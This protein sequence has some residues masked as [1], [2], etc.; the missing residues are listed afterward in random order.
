MAKKDAAKALPRLR[1][2]EFRSLS[3]WESTL[4]GD[5]SIPVTERVGDRKLTPISISAG[6]GFVP[7][8]EKFG[9]DISGNQYVLYTLVRDGDFVY[10]KGNSQKFPQGCIYQLQ[11][12]GEVAAPNAFI[13]FR[14]KHGFVPGY[15]KYCFE[16]NIHGEQLRKSITSGARSNGLLN[17]SKEQ[18]Y[19]ISI[20]TPPR[21]E[22]QRI[23]DCLSSLDELIAAQGRKVEALNAHKRGL[24]QVLFPREGESVPRLRFPEFRDGLEWEEK[25]LKAFAKYENGKAYEQDIQDSG[26]YVVVNSRFISTNGDVRKYSNANYC[27]ASVGDVL[28]VLSDLPKG[29]ALAK[30]FYVDSNLKYAV[31]QRVARLTP[32]DVHPMFLYY[33]LN[34]H[35]YLLSFDDGLS[36]THLSKGSVTDCPILIPTD[37]A[38]QQRIASCLSSLDALI[39]AESG[40]LETLKIH[41]KGLMQGLFPATEDFS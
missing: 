16:K 10:N 3:S 26:N 31:N 36:Q 14:L 32:T 12:W 5:A 20:P 28:M 1:F 13:S 21:G 22:Q 6:I 35:P 19:S 17:I 15:F 25:P 41:K 2:P 33:R 18:F 34:R 38:E 8:V 40:K 24:M 29:R 30:C 27:I 11:G 4:L 37:K 9:R 39:A 23:A 7:Q